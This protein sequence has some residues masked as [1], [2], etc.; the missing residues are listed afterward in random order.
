MRK[1][2]VDR[3]ISQKE[4]WSILN[5]VINYVQYKGNTIDYFKLDIKALEA[6]NQRKMY[7]R[8]KEADRQVVEFDFVI[9]QIS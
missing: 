5:I 3:N 2:N 9:L 8:L 7:D 4:Q 1:N 6:K